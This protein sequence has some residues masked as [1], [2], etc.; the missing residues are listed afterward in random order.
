MAGDTRWLHVAYIDGAVTA[1]TPVDANTVNI[2]LTGGTV[3]HVAFNADSVG[4]TLMLG[5]TSI[6]LG[7][8]ID[9]LAE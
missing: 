3:A 4:G 2:T 8:T 7:A 1:V 9:T 5:S 6:S